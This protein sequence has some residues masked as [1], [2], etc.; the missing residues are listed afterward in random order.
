[1]GMGSPADYS[2]SAYNSLTSSTARCY[3]LDDMEHNVSVQ[4]TLVRFCRGAGIR[5][6]VHIRADQAMP[7]LLVPFFE[8]YLEE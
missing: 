6:C 3:P 5:F 7:S 4:C 8:V 2:P 1:M